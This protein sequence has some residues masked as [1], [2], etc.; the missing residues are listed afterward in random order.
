MFLWYL[1]ACAWANLAEDLGYSDL[2]REGFP[3]PDKS[4]FG[5]RYLLCWGPSHLNQ[6]YGHGSIS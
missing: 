3:S 2:W 6:N 4:P 1:S 5:S